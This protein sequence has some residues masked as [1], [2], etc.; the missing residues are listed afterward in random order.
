MIDVSD[1]TSDA[2]QRRAR[3]NMA[4]GV[5]GWRIFI[6]HTGELRDFPRES[7][8]VA[9]VERAIAAAGHVVVDM[10]DFPAADQTPSELCAERV[11]SCDVY[12]GLLGTRYGSPVLDRPEVSYTELEFET[13]T[14]AGLD[15][16]VFLLDTNAENVG[17][18]PSQLMDRQF[19]DRQDAFR[20]RVRDGELTVQTFGNAAKLGQ[21]VERSLRSLREL[22][23][24]SGRIVSGDSAL[25]DNLQDLAQDIH[26]FL[27]DRERDDPS[28]MPHW[29]RYTPEMTEDEKNAV[30][31]QEMSKVSE[32]YA[33]TMRRFA[34]RFQAK[35]LARFEVL[36]EL[37]LV[38][39]TD[40]LVFEQPINPLGVAELATLLGLAAERLRA[41]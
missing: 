22:A 21:L 34:Q 11:R 16:L 18:P 37:G 35:A 9:E 6:S 25:A 33:E 4:M 8:Y 23:N 27:G 30:Y 10:R 26:T 12:V 7:S 38:N 3:L 24:T 36:E 20:D 5:G 40:R 2:R 29:Y 19:G 41:D 13:A 32:Y 39:G 31:W 14:A 15:R 28:R 1:A 17:I